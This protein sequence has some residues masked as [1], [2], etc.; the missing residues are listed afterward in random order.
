M[1]AQNWKAKYEQRRAERAA[2]RDQQRAEME[3]RS[4]ERLKK[5]A[6]AR[7]SKKT[8]GKAVILP[9]A[10]PAGGALLKDIFHTGGA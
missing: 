4:A 10:R 5:L 3:R 9:L 1:A 6:E 8:T 7:A 2:K